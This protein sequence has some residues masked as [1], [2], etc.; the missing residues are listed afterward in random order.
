MGVIFGLEK[1]KT[2]S[3]VN[4]FSDSQYVVNGIEKGWAQ[5]W[6][7]N[8][9]F[10]TKNEKATNHDLWERLLTVIAIHEKVTFN[11]VKGHAGNIE[12]ERCDELALIALKGN[13]LLIDAGYV[14]NTQQNEHSDGSYPDANFHNAKVNEE[15]DSCRKCHTTVI[16]KQTKNKTPKPGQT[17]YF[18][19]YLFCPNCKT[20]YMVEAAKRAIKSN[21]DD[22]FN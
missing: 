21:E 4:I 20:M 2:R 8:N 22:L 19:Y 6:K 11:W 3:I 1:L 7:S 18:D 5:K 9:W 10:R 15:G 17:Y 16:K 13:S 12:N 14:P